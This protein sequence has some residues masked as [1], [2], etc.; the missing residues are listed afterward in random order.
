MSIPRFRYPVG[1]IVALNQSIPRMRVSGK[2]KTRVTLDAG[3][4]FQVA[5]HSDYAGS[6]E[7]SLLDV[8]TGDQWAGIPEHCLEAVGDTRPAGLFT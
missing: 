6:P 4:Q 7:Y 5:G 1:S 2:V 8:T 3:R